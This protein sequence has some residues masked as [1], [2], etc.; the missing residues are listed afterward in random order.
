MHLAADEAE[1]DHAEG[2]GALNFLAID[3]LTVI[4]E[5][6]DV[7]P[8]SAIVFEVAEG[9]KLVFPLFDWSLSL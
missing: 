2:S 6:E 7:D 9:G 3:D 5:G 4:Q 8:D 1:V